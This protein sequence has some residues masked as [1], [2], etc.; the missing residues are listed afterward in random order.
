M[1]LRPSDAEPAQITSALRSFYDAEVEHRDQ[2]I[3]QDWK[4]DERAVF[5]TGSSGSSR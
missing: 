3:K 1:S 5:T 2:L 4:L